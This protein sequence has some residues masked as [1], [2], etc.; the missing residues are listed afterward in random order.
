MA[1]SHTYPSTRK[2]T[3]GAR[4]RIAL[5][6]LGVRI[7][8]NHNITVTQEFN[9]NTN[10][11][12][13]FLKSNLETYLTAETQLIFNGI[14]IEIAEDVNLTT[15]STPVSILDQS[16]GVIIP[17]NT[18][19]TTQALWL[20]A[21]CKNFIISPEIQTTDTSNVSHGAEREEKQTFNSKKINIDLIEIYGD[22]GGALLIKLC[23][24]LSFRNHE[25][26]FLHTYPDG[27]YKRGAAI[28]T[29]CSP[30]ANMQSLR[31]FRIDARVQPNTYNSL[32]IV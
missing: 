22:V 16:S 15:T 19:S 20:V 28:V 26:W 3:L 31:S 14:I 12:I 32:N 5:L 23:E 24:D 10:P 11:G 18:T 27:N 21:G 30:T 2:T 4:L 6:P 17:I 29:S 9:S 8:K 13:I 7:P 1:K 25:F